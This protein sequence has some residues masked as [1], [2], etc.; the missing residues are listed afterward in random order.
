MRE[1]NNTPYTDSY[2]TTD[3]KIFYR[4]SDI[5]DVMESAT[6]EELQAL[7]VVPSTFWADGRPF[8][9]PREIFHG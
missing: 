8:F 4:P 2:I 3:G 6:L 7:K 1:I 5:K 9:I